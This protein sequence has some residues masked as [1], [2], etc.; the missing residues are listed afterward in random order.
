MQGLIGTNVF[1]TGSITI[2]NFVCLIK[3]SDQIK[4]YHVIPKKENEIEFI[5][6]GEELNTEKD[7]KE[8]IK[9][10]NENLYQK[11]I[12]KDDIF[13]MLEIP[14]KNIENDLLLKEC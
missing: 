8:K 1:E 5:R 4:F 13:Y 12:T 10:I 14:I 6:D 2:T 11:K 3:N 9:K 7:I